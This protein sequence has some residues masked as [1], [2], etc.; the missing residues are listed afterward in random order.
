MSFKEIMQS[1]FIWL[2]VGGLLIGPIGLV[3]YMP[4]V[5]AIGN[6]MFISGFFT[7]VLFT[8]K[9]KMKDAVFGGVWT[10]TVWHFSIAGLVATNWLLLAIPILLISVLISKYYG[11]SFSVK[12]S[13]SKDQ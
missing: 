7:P 2:I 10:Y 6:A 4:V 13:E 9:L 3:L 5:A 1:T 12:A 11:S 8:R